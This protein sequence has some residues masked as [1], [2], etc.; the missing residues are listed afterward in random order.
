MEKCPALICA[1]GGSRGL[2]KKNIKLL[3]GKPLIAHAI[4]IAKQCDFFS[5]VYVSTDCNEIANIASSFGAKIPYLRDPSLATDETP[6]WLVWQDFVTKMKSVNNSFPHFVSL[7]TTAPLRE[8]DDVKNALEKFIYSR[9][10]GL[11]TITEAHRNPMFN[12]VKLKN[13]GTLE[14]AIKP[15]NKVHRR[16]DAAPFFDITTVCYVMKS[17]YVLSAAHMLAG[18]I[19][20]YEIPRERSLDIDTDFDFKLA[21]ILTQKK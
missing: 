8:K 17:D 4:E 10:D 13:D 11:I 21:Q 2:P 20:Y 3:N 9:A 7:P 12:M 15:K 18:K 14:L 1:R 16:Q 19:A 6:E 5:D